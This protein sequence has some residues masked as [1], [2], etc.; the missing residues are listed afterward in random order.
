VLAVTGYTNQVARHALLDVLLD[1]FGVN[2]SLVSQLVAA[3]KQD[4]GEGG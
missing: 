1:V 3:F 2:H 4:E